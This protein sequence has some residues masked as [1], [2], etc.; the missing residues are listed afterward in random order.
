MLSYISI[1]FS[2]I[3]SLKTGTE[4]ILASQIKVSYSKNGCHW[5]Q[6]FT[7]GTQWNL[8]GA[9]MGIMT[10]AANLFIYPT[11]THH[12]PRAR[13]QVLSVLETVLGSLW[14]CDWYG[15]GYGYCYAYC[16]YNSISHTPH[17]PK[18]T[19][20]KHVS[21]RK[22]PKHVDKINTG[23]FLAYPKSQ[24]RRHSS[25]RIPFTIVTQNIP[26]NTSKS[27]WRLKESHTENRKRTLKKGRKNGDSVPC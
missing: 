17:M 7:W 9:G 2:D 13:L 6:W 25:R 4:R 18:C 14:S 22:S 11:N 23:S 8:R 20:V 1:P 10:M 24:G 16:C 5:S 19:T 26:Q 3:N 15:Y 12:G 27:S 21:A